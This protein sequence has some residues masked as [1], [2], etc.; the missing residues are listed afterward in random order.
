MVSWNT[1]KCG[2]SS[3]NITPGLFSSWQQAND[4][5]N[6]CV[7]GGGETTYSVQ[8]IETNSEKCT[9][10]TQDFVTWH[11]YGSSIYVHTRKCW[12]AKSVWKISY[13]N[14]KFT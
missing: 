6:I 9:Y 11:I 5:G 13:E 3:L 4:G 14:D 1:I 2:Y 8:H 10:V 12:D 7:G